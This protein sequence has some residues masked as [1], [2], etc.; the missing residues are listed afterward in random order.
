MSNYLVYI[1]IILSVFS[2]IPSL[3][4]PRGSVPAQRI[5]VTF[6][7]LSGVFGLTAAFCTFFTN[8]PNDKL[9]NLPWLAMGPC[10]IGVDALSAFFLIPVF[11]MGALGSIYGLGYWAQDHHSYNSRKLIL[12]WGLL[13]A[14]MA[15]LVSSKHAMAFL[16]GWELMALSAFFLVTTEDEHGE[17]REA[18]WIYLIATHVGTLVLFAL[19]SLWRWSTGSYMFMPTAQHSMSFALMNVFFFMA[20]IGFGL[21]AGVMPLHF[22]LPAAH[23]TAPS[24]VSAMLSGV[25]LKMGIYG[26]LRWISLFPHPPYLWGTILLIAGFVSGLLGVIFAIAQHDLKR[27]LAYHSV[28]NIGIILMGLGVAVLGRAANNPVLMVL[29]MAGCLLHVWNHSFFKSLLFLCAGSVVHCAHTRQ[30]DKLGGLGKVMPWTA[31]FFLIGSVAICGLPPLNG[32]ISELFVY[33]GLFKIIISH[34][35]GLLAAAS[36]VALAMIGALAGACFVKVYGAVFLGNSRNVNLDQKCESPV[37]MRIPMIVF[38]SV[39]II[40]GIFPF[41]FNSILIQAISVWSNIPEIKTLSLGEVAPLSAISILGVILISG[42]VFTAILFKFRKNEKAEIGTWDCGYAMPSN[43]MQYTA[44][45]FADSLIIMFQWILHPREH[46]PHLTGYFPESAAF[47]SHINELILDRMLIPFSNI[48]KR[49]SGWFHRFQQGLIQHYILYI[50]ITLFLLMCAQIP[51]R[52]IV[53][54]WFIH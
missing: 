1:A 26:L 23:A 43:K 36:V 45:S 4:F 52:E 31:A 19:F 14:G 5:A 24:H 2:G 53:H 3:L 41:L 11:L 35:N 7:C 44:S 29:G 33:L 54:S 10:Y 37:S 17:C 9:L 18:G 28:E 22:W 32:F 13:V 47:N 16:L 40:I 20:F 6:M 51:I 38:A 21:K 34:P 50:C 46:K 25:V 42:I 27:L 12:F 48:V 15:L 39:C 49:C 8:F 30:I